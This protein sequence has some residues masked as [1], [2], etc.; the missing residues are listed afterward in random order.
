MSPQLPSSGTSQTHVTCF[1]LEVTSER[2]SRTFPLFPG[3]IQV[4][5]ATSTVSLCFLLN[6][7]RASPNLQERRGCPLASPFLV[8][9]APAP[10]QGQTPPGPAGPLGV[11]KVM[12]A[13]CCIWPWGCLKGRAQAADQCLPHQD[14]QPAWRGREHPTPLTTGP[15]HLTWERRV[16]LLAPPPPSPLTQLSPT[17]GLHQAAYVQV[18][19]WSVTP[20][21]RCLD[22]QRGNPYC[23]S[24]E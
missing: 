21:G 1:W 19:P 18:L 10:S 22:T 5:N 23:G 9:H 17:H 2:L 16:H 12:A 13:S 11:H 4:G 20:C 24:G 6:Q 15:L 3:F 7:Q 8:T 14:P